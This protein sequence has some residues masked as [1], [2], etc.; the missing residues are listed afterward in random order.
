LRIVTTPVSEQTT[1]ERLEAVL[2]DGVPRTYWEL[3]EILDVTYSH[4][5]LAV[6]HARQSGRTT[7]MTRTF[8]RSNRHYVFLKKH[9][10]KLGSVW[11]TDLVNRP[12]TFSILMKL[13]EKKK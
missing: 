10:T 12:I 2:A 9:A 8:Q 11:N 5:Y 6:Y 3:A 13:G 4:A 7:L 1:L